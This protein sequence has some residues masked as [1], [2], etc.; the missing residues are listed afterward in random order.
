LTHA[1]PKV[2][3]NGVCSRYEPEAGLGT[4]GKI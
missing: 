1:K 3:C 4:D 2:L